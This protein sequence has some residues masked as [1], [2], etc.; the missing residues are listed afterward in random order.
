MACV[1]RSLP[2]DLAQI[3]HVSNIVSTKAADVSNANLT[4]FERACEGAGHAQAVAG[5]AHDA[6][7]I[8]RALAAHPYKIP[9]TVIA[10]EI[11]DQGYRGGMTILSAL[12]ELAGASSIL[13]W[14]LTL[15]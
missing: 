9:A 6:A 14:L 1:Q 12:R 5:G 8:A 2:S 13:G 3:K 7:G 15:V 4:R 11:R 10:R